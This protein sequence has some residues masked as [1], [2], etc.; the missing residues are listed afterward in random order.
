MSFARRRL[1][2]FRQR[3][4]LL[5][6]RGEFSVRADPVAFG[7]FERGQIGGGAELGQRRLLERLDFG[8]QRHADLLTAELR[9]DTPEIVRPCRQGVFQNL[10]HSAFHPSPGSTATK[11]GGAAGLILI[12]NKT[13][14]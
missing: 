3:A 7:L 12:S 8:Q 6:Q 2:L 10:C 5:H 1:L 13:K 11:L 14:S 4:E 9:K